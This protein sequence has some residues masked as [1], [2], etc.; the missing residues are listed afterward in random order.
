VVGR[1]G[2][3]LAE[4]TMAK[5][6][7]NPRLPRTDNLLHERM[8]NSE[9]VPVDQNGQTDWSALVLGDSDSPSGHAGEAANGDLSL[10]A[11][12]VEGLLAENLHLRNILSDLEQRIEQG[13]TENQQSWLE[14]QREYET[15]L[16]EKSELIRSLH[17]KIKELEE[18]RP[19]AKPTPK[20]E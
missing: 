2:E 8:P 6:I 1:L 9:G 10:H 18:T 12:D 7:P 4:G 17:F 15:I 19:A 16:E 20:E 14:R 5:A 13:S 3:R 11:T